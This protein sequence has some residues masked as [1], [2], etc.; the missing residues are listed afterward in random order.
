M[1]VAKFIQAVFRFK[2]ILKKKRLEK[3]KEELDKLIKRPEVNRVAKFIQAVFRFKR[4]LKKKR[5]GNEKEQLEKQ[6]QNPQ[7]KKATSKKSPPSKPSK[8]NL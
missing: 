7:K 1:K 3:E 6:N 5:L 8:K 2:K 4:T